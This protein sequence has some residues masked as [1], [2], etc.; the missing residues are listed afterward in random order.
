M[1]T[2]HIVNAVLTLNSHRFLIRVSLK[3]ELHSKANDIYIETLLDLTDT[4]DNLLTWYRT[5]LTS[6]ASV[7]EKCQNGKPYFTLHI[8]YCQADKQTMD[9][10]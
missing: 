7:L 4:T 10:T 8:F 2:L 3:C 1:V 9:Q 5:L 6:R